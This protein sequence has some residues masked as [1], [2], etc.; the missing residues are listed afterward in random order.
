[1]ERPMHRSTVRRGV[2]SLLALTLSLLLA[3]GPVVAGSGR[4]DDAPDVFVEVAALQSPSPLPAHGQVFLV[5]ELFLT[6]FGREPVTLAALDVQ[7]GERGEVLARFAGRD[8][9]DMLRPVGGAAAGDQ[10]VLLPGRR[11]IAFLWLEFDS[12]AEIPAGLAHTLTFSPAQP[13][14]PPGVVHRSWLEVLN[15]PAVV[16][17]P[18]TYGGNWLAVNAPADAA[19]ATGHRITP[20]VVDG[21]VFFAQ[22]YAIDL[23][24]IGPDGFSYQGDPSLNESY[25]AY[26]APLLAVADGVVIATKDGI[27]ENDP[28]SPDRAVP[29]TLET[30]AG[31][32]VVIDIGGGRYADYAHLIPGSLTVRPGDRV[33][34]GDVIGLVG[35][36]GNSTEAH[37]HFHIT[38]GPSFVAANGVPYAFDAVTIR[39]ITA[40]DVGDDDFRILV[41]DDPPYH[42]RL[43]MVLNNDLLDFGAP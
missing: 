26:G 11:T 13:G 27:P 39:S 28:R 19:N 16:I 32:Y 17:G 6:N 29:I 37:L 5:Y 38:D 33:R 21:E 36:S 30:V 7:D 25:H 20:L 18:P 14:D 12:A 3:G 42:A 34:R 8:L 40:G 24:Q 1:M 10:R 35:N 4:S 41:T 15:E 9:T 22:R 31:N 2:V 23:I 43:E